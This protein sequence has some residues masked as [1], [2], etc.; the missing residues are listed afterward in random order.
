[1]CGREAITEGTEGTLTD[2]DEE[3]DEVEEEAWHS[4]REDLRGVGEGDTDSDQ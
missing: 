3:D 1:M 4:A 2:D